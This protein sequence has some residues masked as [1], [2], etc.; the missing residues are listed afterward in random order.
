MDWTTAIIE[1]YEIV[2]PYS[3]GRYRKTLDG[4]IKDKMGVFKNYPRVTGVIVDEL[5]G[6]YWAIITLKPGKKIMEFDV[7]T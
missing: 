3:V 7:D 4:Q 1:K 6:P 2:Y 5:L